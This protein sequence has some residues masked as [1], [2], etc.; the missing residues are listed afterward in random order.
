MPCYVLGQRLT[1]ACTNK[2]C[3]STTANQTINNNYYYRFPSVTPNTLDFISIS[4]FQYSLPL[5][6]GPVKQDPAED[7]QDQ[8]QH[9]QGNANQEPSANLYA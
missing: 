2:L 4:M 3:N 9:G 7:E 1:N 8:G 6:A 5:G